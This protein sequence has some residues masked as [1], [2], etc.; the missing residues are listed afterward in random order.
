MNNQ[1]QS[2]SPE[3]MALLR[4]QEVIDMN[5]L[6]LAVAVEERDVRLLGATDWNPARVFHFSLRSNPAVE[7]TM[8][9]DADPAYLEQTL[10]DVILRS[11]QEKITLP[12]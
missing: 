10:P 12:E 4:A 11:Y 1:E 3:T 6:D 2:N 9:V 5:G 8:D 7:W